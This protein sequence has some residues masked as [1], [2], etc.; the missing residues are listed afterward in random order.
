MEEI[1]GSKAKFVYIDEAIDMNQSVINEVMYEVEKK[2]EK[3]SSL[4]NISKRCKKC[5]GQG[6]Y[7]QSNGELVFCFR[8]NG[9]G[10]LF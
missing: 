8:C 1:T 5:F 6:L 2:R 9:K 4:T 3:K 10:Y 7:P